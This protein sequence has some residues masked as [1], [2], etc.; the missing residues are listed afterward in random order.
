M[1][2]AK[3]AAVTISE[4]LSAGDPDSLEDI[5]DEECLREVK[6]NL[7]FF[8]PQQRGILAV[9]LDD[10]V[11]SFAYQVGIILGEE[12]EEISKEIIFHSMIANDMLSNDRDWQYEATRGDND[13]AHG[14]A[15][16]DEEGHGEHE[17]VGD[18]WGR[19]EEHDKPW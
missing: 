1:E 10:F 18:D 9:D 15:D 4:R 13:G 19:Q 6:R 11:W 16:P 12:Q 2:G 17:P 5:V 7:S 3:M 8:R 14:D